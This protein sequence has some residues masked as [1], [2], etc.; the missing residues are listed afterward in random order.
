MPA[1]HRPN[2]ADATAARRRI[3]DR[4]A[5]ARLTTAGYIVIPPG[6]VDALTHT[7]AAAIETDGNSCDHRDDG[8]CS[9]CLAT[10]S[11]RTLQAGRA[12]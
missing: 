4:A 9:T 3:G 5:A 7:I 10:L 8:A 11:I 6:A 12:L 1:P 2:T